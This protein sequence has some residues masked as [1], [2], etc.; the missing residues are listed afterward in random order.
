MLSSILVS[1]SGDDFLREVTRVSGLTTKVL[2]MQ[3]ELGTVD[4]QSQAV[5]F[6]IV[7]FL[8]KNPAQKH[9]VGRLCH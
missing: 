1:I 9:S 6:F 8:G 2:F 4:A 3:I 5:H 7:Y